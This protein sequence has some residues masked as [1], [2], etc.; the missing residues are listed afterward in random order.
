MESFQ[1]LCDNIPLSVEK[2]DNL[3]Q[4]VVERQAEF[5]RL[6]SSN[7][8]SRARKKKTGSTESLRP[9]EKQETTTSNIPIS[10]DAPMSTPTAP[11]TPLSPPLPVNINP[12]NRRLFQEYREAQRKKRKSQ[13][14]ISGAS[15]PQKVRTRLSG[16]VFYDAAIQNGFEALVKGVAS[17]RNNL[18]KGKMAASY[19]ER[20]ASLKMEESPFDGNRSNIAIRNPMI[21][22]FQRASAPY[23][24]DSLFLEQFDYIDKD[25]EEAQTMCELGA[26]Q[27]LRDGDCTDELG[28]IRDKLNNCIKLAREG[29]D[30]MK[31]EEEERKLAQQSASRKLSE[32]ERSVL[33]SAH[34]NSSDARTN[35]SKAYTDSA[36]EIESKNEIEI[37]HGVEIEIDIPADPDNAPKVSI[38]GE[39]SNGLIEVDEGEDTHSFHIDLSSFRRT[40]PH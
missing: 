20:M 27:F 29:Y 14:I 19:N 22:Q 40:R 24:M 4:Q 10:S 15:G 17:A 7:S 26:H 33:A 36:M 16:I 38:D 13:S 37:D 8:L 11:T 23:S 39:F 32:T 35:L 12:N 6:S 18:R 1:H 25:L 30:I 34:S 3:C 28:V 21:P 31:A 5:E 2:L 9:N